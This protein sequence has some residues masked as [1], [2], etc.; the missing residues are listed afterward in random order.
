TASVGGVAATITF[1]VTNLAGAPSVISV[2]SGSGQTATVYTDFAAPLI[3]L[4]T[5][6]YGNAVPGI[7]V[8]FTAPSAGPGALFEGSVTGTS[9]TGPASKATSPKVTANG[10][11]GSYTVLATTPGVATSAAFTLTNT[12]AVVTTFSADTYADPSYASVALGTS[13]GGAGPTRIV[14]VNAF[15]T[16]QQAVNATSPGGTVHVDAATYNEAVTVSSPM[17]LQG[18]VPS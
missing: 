11:A 15:P 5:D 6:A 10:A 8:T 17:T 9:K 1:N 7:P 16:I 13:V 12:A 3:A 18:N 14:G 4:V 2:V